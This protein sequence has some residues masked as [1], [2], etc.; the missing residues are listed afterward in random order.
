MLVLSRKIGERIVVGDGV[1]V[2]ILACGPGRVRVG[3]EAPPW[4]AVARPDARRRPA[5]AGRGLPGRG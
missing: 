3:V 4:V 5:A 2:V 1:A